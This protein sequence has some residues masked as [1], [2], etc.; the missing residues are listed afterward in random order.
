ME[1]RSGVRR[2]L[3]YSSIDNFFF[4]VMVGAGETFLPAFA[5]AVGMSS[6]IVGLIASLP[7]LIGSLFQLAAPGALKKL[8]SYRRWLTFMA[9]LQASS[10]LPLA[11][12]GWNGE[13]AMSVPLFFAIVTVYWGCGLASGPAWS[14]WMSNLVPLR[15]R[16]RY[17]ARRSHLGQFGLAL[18]LVLGGCLLHFAKKG[19]W[20]LEAFG[21][22][23]LVSSLFR[24]VSSICLSRQ[25][26][27]PRMLQAQKR[28]SLKDLLAR[29]RHG[30]DGRLIGFLLL[31]AA[32]VHLSAPFF[33]PYMLKVL[34]LDYGPYMTLIASSFVA[35]IIAFAVLAKFSGRLRPLM[36]MR[37]GI[38]GSALLPVLWVCGSSLGYLMI[39]EIYG[40]AVWATFEL[41]VM[42]ALFGAI[43]DEERTS[44]LT[45]YNFASAL[46]IF[47]GSFIG[48][49]ILS[50]LGE[51]SSTYFTIFALS[52]AARFLSLIAFETIAPEALSRYGGGNVPAQVVEAIGQW[53]LRQKSR[54]QSAPLG[55]VS[56]VRLRSKS[57]G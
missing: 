47:G 43:R 4:S 49:K 30:R 12:T 53:G 3:R 5:V 1:L 45:W 55:P 50:A 35:K 20:E 18:G 13:K 27:S 6:M 46:M 42:L 2:D 19:G 7:F 29:L 54:I 37:W 48:G 40:G 36:L 23:F 32:S 56:L 10:F 25:S 52:A 34:K 28:V 51:G 14:S 39:V 57:R 24:V 26:E 41:G 22:L 16:S 15:V 33:N 44:F 9:L 38:V 17:F 8:G 11:W 31:F 21:A